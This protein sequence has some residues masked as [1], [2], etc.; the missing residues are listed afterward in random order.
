[1][2][3]T[4]LVLGA[5]MILALTILLF[6]SGSPIGGGIMAA[7]LV[8]YVIMIYCSK[9]KIRIGIVLLETA[10]NFLIEKPS[11]FIAPFFMVIIVFLF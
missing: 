1:M 7:M 9:E 8:F 4:M 10:A 11:V 5:V 3:Y 6:V 2:F